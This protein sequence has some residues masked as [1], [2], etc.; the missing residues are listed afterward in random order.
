M[1]EVEFAYQLLKLLFLII[2][3]EICHLKHRADIVLHCHLPEYRCLLRQ[4]AYPHLGSFVHGVRRNALGADDRR[5]LCALKVLLARDII[6]TFLIIKVDIASVRCYQ[7]RRHVERRRLTGT[8][9]TQQA[10]YL[11]LVNVD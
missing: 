1:T 11:T 6:I 3:G 5:V 2:L 10:H 8:V 4:I 9:W 7:A